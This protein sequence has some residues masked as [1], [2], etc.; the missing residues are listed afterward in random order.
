M[1]RSRSNS[2]VRSR[3]NSLTSQVLPAIGNDGWPPL[4]DISYPFPLF[5]L[6]LFL[7]FLPSYL[8]GMEAVMNALEDTDDPFI[9]PPV[10]AMVPVPPPTSRTSSWKDRSE[11]IIHRDD[12]GST[13]HHKNNTTTQNNTHHN[14]SHNSSN[15]SSIAQKRE[16]KEMETGAVSIEQVLSSTSSPNT[17]TSR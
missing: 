15:N 17:S 7:I 9:P 6:F 16:D 12:S 14:T 5:P 4:L 3:Q 10:A 1:V 8:P 11:H 2:S 13:N